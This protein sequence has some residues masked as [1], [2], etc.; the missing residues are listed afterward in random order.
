MKVLFK[1]TSNGNTQYDTCPEENQNKLKELFEECG[2]EVEIYNYPV[3]F[4]AFPKDVQEEIKKILRAYDEVNVTFEMR[5]FHVSPNVSICSS[6]PY[7]HMVCSRF[8]VTQ[9][10]T[11]EERRQ[12]FFEEFGYVPFWLQ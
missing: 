12:N 6:Y 2:C 9:M 4:K 10:Y 5:K 3:P 8:H 11:K 1:V 7:D